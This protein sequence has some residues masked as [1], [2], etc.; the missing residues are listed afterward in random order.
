M[1][2]TNHL[3]SISNSSL[4]LQDKDDFLIHLDN[5]QWLKV[6][7]LNWKLRVDL[8]SIAFVLHRPCESLMIVTHLIH[9]TPF[10]GHVC[11]PA[12]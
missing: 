5:E 4:L 6:K 7:K 9:S 11:L 8:F 1:D 12:R 2:C 3:L 10:F